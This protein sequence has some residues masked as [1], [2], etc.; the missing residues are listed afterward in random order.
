[1]INSSNAQYMIKHTNEQSTDCV[2]PWCG[3]PMKATLRISAGCSHSLLQCGVVCVVGSGC[4]DSDSAQNGH[5]GSS[6]KLSENERD[7]MQTI[8]ILLVELDGGF[9]L[10]GARL[11]DEHSHILRRSLMRLDIM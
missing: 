2:L 9:G 3:C 8:G 10:L 4:F 1:M 7:V 11:L 6:P 5:I